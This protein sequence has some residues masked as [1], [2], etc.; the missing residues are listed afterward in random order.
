MKVKSIRDTGKA[1]LI[2]LINDDIKLKSTITKF[3]LESMNLKEGEMIF[4][5]FKAKS[6]H[7]L[8]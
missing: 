1:I 5:V 4:A 8:S 6:L 2:E 3:S 7:E